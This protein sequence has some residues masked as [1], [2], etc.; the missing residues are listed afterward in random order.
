MEKEIIYK[1]FDEVLRAFLDKSDIMFS[2]GRD[3]DWWYAS[4]LGTCKRQHFMR[5]MGLKKTNAQKF[6]LRF[7]GKDGTAGHEWREIA[8]KSMGV[9][10]GAEERL[11]DEETRYRGKYD[12]LVKLNNKLVLV[13][14]KTQRS[15]A[16][17]YRKKKPLGE[18]V[19]LY[20]KFQLASY[21]YFAKRIYPELEEARIYYVDRGSG[22]REEFIFKFDDEMFDLVLGELNYLNECWKKKIIPPALEKKDWKCQFCDYKQV[23]REVDKNKLTFNKTKQNYGKEITCSKKSGGSKSTNSKPKHTRVKST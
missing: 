12:L 17:F 22:E 7:V 19:P 13:D 11:I 20:Q 10:I 4:S 3:N 6:S 16:F 14:I 2:K 23:C 18:K 5:R 21:V 15:E 1:S 9:V 8:A